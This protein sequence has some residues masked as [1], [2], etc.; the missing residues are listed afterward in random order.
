MLRSEPNMVQLI[1]HSLRRRAA[2]AIRPVDEPGASRWRVVLGLV[3]TLAAVTLL[4]ALLKALRLPD[5]TQTYEFIY[6]AV[7]VAAAGVYGFPAA[8]AGSLASALAVDYF[9]LPPVGR[10][11]IYSTTETL[12]WVAFLLVCLA[13]A[14]LTNA[15]RRHLLR[16]RAATAQLRASNLELRAAEAELEKSI[17]A[18]TELARTE[19]ALA[20]TRRAEAFRRELLATVSHELRTP[21]SSLLG[22]STALSDADWHNQRWREY[23]QLIA[24]EARRMNRLLDDLL[25]MARID[26]GQVHIETQV[27]DLGDAAK[28]AAQRWA[29]TLDLQVTVPS[30]P[31]LVIADWQRV[32][33]VLDNALRNVELHSG[34]TRADIAVREAPPYRRTATELVVRDHGHGI[35][36]EVRDRLFQRYASAS[37]GG[38]GLGLAVS[39]GLTEAMG[40]ALWID[41]APD[42]GVQFHLMLPRPSQAAEPEAVPVLLASP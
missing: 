17:A 28:E 4:T 34:Q 35:A 8:M 1:P 10:L 26:T 22:Y 5:H 31:T 20:A 13:V 27:M 25:E 11:T 21:L 15:R 39:R 32:Q 18:R 33:Q 9:F 24:A 37:E 23:P 7:V 3:L 19:A 29:R 12:A 2:G 42:S 40:G 38:L 6:L 36:P 41:H 30:S 14:G 16:L